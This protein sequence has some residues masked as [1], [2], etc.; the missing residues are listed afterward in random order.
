MRAKVEGRVAAAAPAAAASSVAGAASAPEDPAAQRARERLLALE[1]SLGKLQAEGRA[2]QASLLQLQ[3]RLREA[4]AQRYANPLVYLLGA[5][6]AL[7]A[8]GLA[9]VLWKR[10]PTQQAGAPWYAASTEVA[11]KVAADEWAVA[12]AD[13]PAPAPRRVDEAPVVET[14]ASPMMLSQVQVLAN[15]ASPVA[16][17]VEVADPALAVEE[18]IDLEQQA[19]FF[20]VLGQDDAAID[21]L[22]GHLRSSGGASPLPYLKLLEIYRRRGDRE[23]SE[24]I[25]ERF[26]LRF[27]A[28]APAWDAD[29]QQGRSLSDY[30]SVVASLQGLWKSPTQAMRALEAS[31]FRRDGSAATFDLPAYRELLF[32]Y[33]VARDLAER[34]EA[35]AVDVDLL[36]PIGAEPAGDAP[37]TRLHPSPQVAARVDPPAEV[38]VDITSLDDGAAIDGGRPSRLHTDFSPTS[39]HL[40]LGVEP[41]NTRH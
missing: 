17:R 5:L 12:P 3:Q 6:C 11:A 40:P 26:N 13:A 15:V 8:A 19:E 16:A 25:R 30:P 36:L 21:L 7:L 1:D 41:S 33:A 14:T 29:P 27:N 39:G 18:L 24:R 32:L 34:S 9:L 28:Y 22:M 10:S 20:V 4:E 38:D 23:A 37:V 31:I 2:T 35:Q